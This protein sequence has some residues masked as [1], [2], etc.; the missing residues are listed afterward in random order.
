MPLVYLDEVAAS[1]GLGDDKEV[2]KRVQEAIAGVLAKQT[3]AGGFGLWIE[4]A[5]DSIPFDDVLANDWFA[6]GLIPT[7]LKLTTLGARRVGENHVAFDMIGED[8]S[9]LRAI[10]FRAADGPEGL[11]ITQGGLLHIA[12]RLRADAWRGKG[13]VQLEVADIAKA[14]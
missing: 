11:A 2:R 10:A 1:I 5:D 6:V 3:S 13:A 7:T 12:G 9:R 8:G 4:N 14:E